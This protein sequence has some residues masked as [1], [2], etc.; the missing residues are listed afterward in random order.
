MFQEIRY[1][2]I[3]VEYCKNIIAG[4]NGDHVEVLNMTVYVKMF[5]GQTICINCGRKQEAKK[6][7]EEVERKTKIP[8]KYIRSANL[9]K[10]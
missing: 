10:K 4:M 7:K 5:N 2:T 1:K 6:I 9:Q 3:T 8:D